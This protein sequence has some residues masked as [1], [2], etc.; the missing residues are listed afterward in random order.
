MSTASTH[1][2]K[3][4]P[5]ATNRSKS[6][7]LAGAGE[8]LTS[9]PTL[10]SE[11]SCLPSGGSSIPMMWANEAGDLIPSPQLLTLHYSLTGISIPHF[12]THESLERALNHQSSKTSDGE[13]IYNERPLSWNYDPTKDGGT[14]DFISCALYREYL[15][16]A[17]HAYQLASAWH[18]IGEDVL[19][20][21]PALPTV[22]WP[23]LDMFV[24]M[25]G[26]HEVWDKHD[27]EIIVSALLSIAY[28]HLGYVEFV[29]HAYIDHICGN[30][31][32]KVPSF[33][34]DNQSWCEEFLS[35]VSGSIPQKIARV[36][37]MVIIWGNI[38]QYICPPQGYPCQKDG[39]SLASAL[40]QLISFSHEKEHIIFL[41][42]AL[43]YGPFPS[44]RGF[45]P[46]VYHVEYVPGLGPVETLVHP[47]HYNAD[48]ANEPSE[49]SSA[50]MQASTS[51]ENNPYHSMYDGAD[52]DDDDWDKSEDDGS[53]GNSKDVDD[54]KALDL[55]AAAHCGDC[56]AC[57]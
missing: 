26:E 17:H 48:I 51:V 43:G 27:N 22:P 8:G 9:T 3:S 41:Q 24:F 18:C 23:W 25:S 11:A 55:I 39:Q 56:D 44:A 19:G 15:G 54:Q 57:N 34:V 37:Q 12:D 10:S 53:Q 1:H 6:G 14:F 28:E 38:L 7:G 13:D 2:A 49:D 32:L 30:N 20:T 5:L 40:E 42:E 47:A 52:N 50:P 29:T 36:F 4:T 31:N 16:F 33:G 45:V 35:L 21:L 46:T